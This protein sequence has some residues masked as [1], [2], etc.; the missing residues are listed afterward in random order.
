MGKPCRVY[1]GNF[2]LYD[3]KAHPGKW[4]IS[5]PGGKEKNFISPVA[6]SEKEGAQTL[7]ARLEGCKMTM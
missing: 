5:V 2:Y 7:V 3:K 1:L 4:N 6:A